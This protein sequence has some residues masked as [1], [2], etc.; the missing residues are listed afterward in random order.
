LPTK[1]GHR[2]SLAAFYFILDLSCA[3]E[4]NLFFYQFAAPNYSVGKKACTT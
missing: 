4:K 1:K 3:E 2:I